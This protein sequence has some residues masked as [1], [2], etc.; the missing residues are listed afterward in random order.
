VLQ[1][2]PQPQQPRAVALQLAGQL[3]AGRPLGDPSGDQDQLAG[4]PADAVQERAG[5]GVEHPAAAAT[6]VVEHRGA[7]AAVD[8]QA[9]ARPAPRAGQAVGMQPAD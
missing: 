6:A 5:E 1:P 7:V 2:V 3:G 4:P 9:V 8:G